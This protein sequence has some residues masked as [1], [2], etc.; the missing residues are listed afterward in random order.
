MRTQ[1][2]RFVSKDKLKNYFLRI[3]LKRNKIASNK[4]IISIFFLFV[5]KRKK[6][7]KKPRN[8]LKKKKNELFQSQM[9]M[10]FITLRNR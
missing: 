7:E 1:K 2:A 9:K 10:K 4:N 8:L 6:S 3:F 5:V